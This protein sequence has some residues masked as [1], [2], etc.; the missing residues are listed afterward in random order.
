MY[1]KRQYDHSGKA[2]RVNGV[3]VLRVHKVEHL[4]PSF[5]EQGMSE[6]WMSMTKGKMVIHGTEGDV[7]MHVVRRPGVYCCHCGERLGDINEGGTVEGANSFRKHMTVSH[8]GAASPDVTNPAGYGQENYYTCTSEGKDTAEAESLAVKV[9]E[10]FLSR[11][12]KY[13]KA[14]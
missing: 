4:S 9:R 13:A 1:L 10:E 5:V 14:K 11:I 8:S 7:E 3:K 2:P 6:G 12:T